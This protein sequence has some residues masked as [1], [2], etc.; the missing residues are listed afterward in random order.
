MVLWNFYGVIGNRSAIWRKATWYTRFSNKTHFSNATLRASG[1]PQ[2]STQFKLYLTNASLRASM[3]Q[4]VINADDPY[5]GYAVETAVSAQFGIGERRRHWR[6][7]NW[8][9]GR[10]QGEVDFVH[11]HQG[12]QRPDI[13]LEVKWSDG[14][15]D[16]PS[17]LDKAISFCEKNG[18]RQLWVTTRTQRGVRK[19]GNVEMVFIPTA[20]FAY[21]LDDGNLFE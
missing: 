9:N 16:H 15:F 14:P 6:Y 11:I 21:Q 7:A 4:P 12:A 8:K 17:E 20:S 5:L 19:M 10:S 18:L 2:C 1:N 3:F 13:A